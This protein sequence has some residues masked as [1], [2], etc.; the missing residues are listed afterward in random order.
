[1]SALASKLDVAATTRNA[2]SRSASSKFRGCQSIARDSACSASTVVSSGET[3][4][5]RAPERSRPA[6]LPSA[7]G[8]PPTTRQGL[9]SSFKKI[10]KSVGCCALILRLREECGPP[11]DRARRQRNFRQQ[12]KREFP[13]TNVERRIAAGS[14]LALAPPDSGSTGARWRQG[15]PRRG[16]DIPPDAQWPDA[17]LPRRQRRSNRRR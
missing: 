6:T 15:L 4:F 16:S 14:R 12:D 7:M 13:P 11:Q 1:M 10:G 17:G 9:P 2:P 5:T 3:T 8:P